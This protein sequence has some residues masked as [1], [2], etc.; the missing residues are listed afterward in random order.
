MDS[1]GRCR[2][3]VRLGPQLGGVRHNL[4]FLFNPGIENILVQP[5]LLRAHL[6]L[7][8]LPVVDLFHITPP[9]FQDIVYPRGFSGITVLSPDPNKTVFD[10]IVLRG[11]KLTTGNR[12]YMFLPSGILSP[13][14][15]NASL[16]FDFLRSGIA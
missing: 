16:A 5:N 2:D 4:G 13:R 6:N 3:L 1:H 11:R 12:I 9:D 8:F 14:R 10:I 7:L 15:F